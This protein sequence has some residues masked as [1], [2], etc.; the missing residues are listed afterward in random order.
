MY[1]YLYAYASLDEEHV[2]AGSIGLYIKQF[3]VEADSHN[4]P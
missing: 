2:N 1:I 4:T 3:P